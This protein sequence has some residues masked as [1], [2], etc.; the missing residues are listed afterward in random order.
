MNEPANLGTGYTPI[1]VEAPPIAPPTKKSQEMVL[2]RRSEI[3]AL[4]RGV[5]RA[6][7]NPVESAFTWASVW[8]GVAVAAG[9]S[10]LAL[11]GVEGNDVR[12]GVITAHAGAVIVGSFLAAYMGWVGHNNRKRRKTARDDLLTELDELNNRAPTQLIEEDARQE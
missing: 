9:L 11:L 5:A 3:T 6:F 4:K 2:V 7:E 10:L 8:L 12:S 1:G